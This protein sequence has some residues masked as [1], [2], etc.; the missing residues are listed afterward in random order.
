MAPRARSALGRAWTGRF[1]FGMGEVGF[2]MDD[3][4]PGECSAGGFTLSRVPR[5]NGSSRAVELTAAMSTRG[6][7]G[8]RW[9][10][11]IRR[12]SLF[13]SRINRTHRHGFRFSAVLALS[14]MPTAPKKRGKTDEQYHGYGL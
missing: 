14:R 13:E 5:P 4:V 2:L 10:S 11:D 9:N 3:P 12:L 1:R 6:G 8:S 7:Q